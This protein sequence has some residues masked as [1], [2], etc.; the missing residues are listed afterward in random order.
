MYRLLVVTK[1]PRVQDM[2]AAMEGWEAMGFKPPRVRQSV[3]EAIESMK[4]HQIDAIAVDENPAFQPLIGNLNKTNPTMPIFE[5]AENADAQWAVCKEVYQLLAQLYADNSN[6]VHDKMYRFQLA[7]ERWIK[8][9]LC[10]MAPTKKSIL[11]HHRL[12]RCDETAD[13]PC[14]YVRFHIPQ[15]NSFIAERWHYGSDRLEV[16]LRNFFGQ[17][18]DFMRFYLAVLSP[19]EVRV[20]VCPKPEYTNH[21]ELEPEQALG[22]IQDTLEQIEDYLGLSMKL[23]EIRRIDGLTAFAAEER[24]I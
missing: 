11:T 12:L 2:F 1:E 21:K 3:E 24:Q 16:A 6:D 22:F 9:L 10:G 14:L 20:M 7:R 4:K 5:I 13:A 8:K 19:K 23:A 15:G 17:E 18:H